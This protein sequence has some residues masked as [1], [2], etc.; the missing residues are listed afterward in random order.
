MAVTAPAPPNN[1]PQFSHA[2]L[3]VTIVLAGS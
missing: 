3:E 1:L 2:R